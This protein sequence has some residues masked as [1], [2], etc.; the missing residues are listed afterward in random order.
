MHVQD[1]RLKGDCEFGSG[2]DYYTRA[3]DLVSGVE[4]FDRISIS[5]L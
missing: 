3:R 2:I 5:K 1:A 4:E